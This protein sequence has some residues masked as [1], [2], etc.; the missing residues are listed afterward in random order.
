MIIEKQKELK[1]PSTFVQQMDQLQSIQITNTTVK[2]SELPD[3]QQHRC[4]K[5]MM[6]AKSK[7]QENIYNMISFIQSS[8]KSKLYMLFRA[9]WT[10]YMW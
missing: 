10:L 2:R 4:L 7:L 5:N 3:I 1:C 9:I 6:I 8:E